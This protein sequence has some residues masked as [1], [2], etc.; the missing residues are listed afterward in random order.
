MKPFRQNVA[1]AIDGGG[2]KGVMVARALS[3]LEEHLG[4]GAPEIFH[5][6]AGTSTGSVLSAGI[7][8]GLNG[9]EMYALYMGLGPMVFHRTIRSRLWPLFRYRYPQRPLKQALQ[10]HL[11][12]LTLGDLWGRSPRIDVVITA[13]DLL[14]NRT[15][16]IKPYKPD[17]ADWSLV[18][19]VLASSA[20]PTYFPIVEGR[21]IDGGVGSYANPVYVAAYE[22]LFQLGWDPAETTLLSLGTG[23]VPVAHDVSRANRWWAWDWLPRILGAFMDSA[24]DQQVHLVDTFFQE[25]DFRRFQVDLH[26]P[27]AMDDASALPVLSAYGEELARLILNDITDRAMELGAGRPMP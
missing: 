4:Q 8:A 7:A 24:T 5:L 27:I 20:V 17:Y 16:F 2:I 9:A 22:L 19:A 6:A 14:E 12:D 25:L 18:K 26:Q 3:I 21:Y 13:F 1:I 15:R 11:G 23:R 10:A